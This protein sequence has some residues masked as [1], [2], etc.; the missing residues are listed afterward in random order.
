MR[1]LHLLA[2]ALAKDHKMKVSL[3]IF[4]LSFFI[5]TPT[6]TTA[7]MAFGKLYTTGVS[8]EY[9]CLRSSHELRLITFVIG[10]PK[11]HCHQGG[12]CGQQH[13]P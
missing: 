4:G 10:Q 1:L 13:R 11:V 6:F 7:E 2:C 3:E 9:I 5:T 8:Y 12:R